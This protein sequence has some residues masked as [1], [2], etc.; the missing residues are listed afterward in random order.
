MQKIIGCKG[1]AKIFEKM[2]KAIEFYANEKH[3]ETDSVDIGSLSIPN[4]SMIA[5]SD[6][7]QY[8]RS[9]L[10]EIRENEKLE[11]GK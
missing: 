10:E 4:S 1:Q 2:K 9:I 8:A 5:S 7:G 3:W 6:C 11:I